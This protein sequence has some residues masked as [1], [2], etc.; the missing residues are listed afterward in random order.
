MQK[1]NI[2]L[3]KEDFLC[4]LSKKPRKNI[5]ITVKIGNKI[6]ISK[7]KY[8]NKSTIIK[9]LKANKKWIVKKSKQLNEVSKK[10]ENYLTKDSFVI[11][12]KKYK[13]DNQTFKLSNKESLENQTKDTNLIKI[14]LN[15][16]LSDYIEAKAREYNKLLSD[17]KIVEPTIKIKQMAGKWGF[18]QPKKD[19]IYLSNNLVHYPKMCIDYVLLH[20]YV[21]LIVP[22]H[23][24]EFYLIIE[25]YMPNYKDAIKYLKTN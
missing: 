13:H 23:S 25:K 14:Y 7:P 9:H 16:I 2:I 11:F 22:N 10:R 12:G 18:C 5:N 21:H 24:K 15:K 19:L 6:N 4:F 20:E 17:Y 1:F 8:V 3:D